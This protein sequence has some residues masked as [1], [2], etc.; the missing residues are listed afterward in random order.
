MA[1]ALLSRHATTETVERLRKE[2]LLNLTEA[3]TA[4]RLADEDPSFGGDAL[5]AVSYLYQRMRPSLAGAPPATL[6]RLA[7]EASSL[8][9]AIDPGLSAR[10]PV[11]P[12][13]AA[14]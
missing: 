4:A 9:R 1:Q 14:A 5:T 8:M 13:G 10:H 3:I 2:F 6:L 7:R 11:I 12:Q